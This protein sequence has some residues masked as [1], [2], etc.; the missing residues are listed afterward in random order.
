MPGTREG[1]LQAAA[2]NKELYGED[3][4]KKI[5][6]QGGTISKGGGFA[7]D[8]EMAALA[9]RL[10]GLKSR[11][12]SSKYDPTSDE[13]KQAKKEIKL[14]KSYRKYNGSNTGR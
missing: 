3:F 13:I 7:K 9:G 11:K 6:K 12:D 5:G 1:G 10:G 14:H 8:S 2:K 4:Y